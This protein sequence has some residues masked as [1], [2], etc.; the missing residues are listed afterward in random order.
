MLIV[1]PVTVSEC[2]A[3]CLTCDDAGRCVKCTSGYIE[4]AGSCVGKFESMYH[5]GGLLMQAEFV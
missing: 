1:C 5:S 3:N 2:D 4:D